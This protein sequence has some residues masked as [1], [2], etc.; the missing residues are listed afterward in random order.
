MLYLK[1]GD[2]LILEITPVQ[3]IR[4]FSAQDLTKNLAVGTGGWGTFIFTFVLFLRQ[5]VLVRVIITV[6][7]HI[8]QNNLG[9]KEYVSYAFTSQYIIKGNQDRDSSKA[10][11][12][13]QELM[14]RLNRCRGGRLF[15]S[16]VLWAYMA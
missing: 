8:D 7:K 6:S 9:R 14:L 16:L 11:T 13:K 15:T 10:K 1:G 2:C 3:G 4:L 12:W 5:N